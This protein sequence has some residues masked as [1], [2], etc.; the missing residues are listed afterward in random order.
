MLDPQSVNSILVV[1]VRIAMKKRSY[2]KNLASMLMLEQYVYVWFLFLERRSAFLVINSETSRAFAIDVGFDL[3]P[4][5]H[6]YHCK[7]PILNLQ[8]EVQ[9]HLAMLSG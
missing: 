4:F 1:F 8:T 5:L 7:L 6:C 3:R 9:V 2:K